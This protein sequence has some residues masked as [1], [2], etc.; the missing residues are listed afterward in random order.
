MCGI[1]GIFD[2]GGKKI[3][4]HSFDRMIDSLSHRGPDG[5]GVYS[6]PEGNLIL[7]HRRLSILDLSESGGQPMPDPSKRYWITFNG[8]IYNFLE[9][10]KELVAL[11]E[12]FTSESDTEIILSAYRQWGADCQLKFNGMWAFAIWDELEKTLFLSRD[13]FGVKPLLYTFDGARLA[14]ASELKAFLFLP[15]FEFEFDPR[16]IATSL[17]DTSLLEP[18]PY[19]LAKEVS[20][21][22]AGHSLSLSKSNGLQIRK[23]WN[24]LDHLPPVPSS[25]RAQIERFR[26]IFTDACRIRMRSD[27]PLGNALSGGLDSSS[28][29][30]VMKGV[31]SNQDRERILESRL[32]AFVALY[33]QTAQDEF[34]FAKEMIERTGVDSRFAP[35]DAALFVKSFDDCLYQHEDLFELPLGPWMLY[36][37]FREENTVISI[38]GHGGDEILG[39]YHHQVESLVYRSL[40]PIPH[41]FR[42]KERLALLNSLYAPGHQYPKASWPL[43]LAKSALYRLRAYPRLQRSFHQVLKTLKQ[44]LKGTK[45]FKWTSAPFDDSIFDSIEKTFPPKL[46]GLNQILFEDFH[47]RTLPMILRNFDRASMAHG[48]EIRAP[49]LDWRL[50]TYAFSLPSETKIGGG[51]TKRI[52][53]EAMRGILPETIRLRKSKI[54]FTNPMFAWI[55]GPLKPFILDTVSSKGFIESPIWNGPSISEYVLESYRVNDLKGVRRAW[56]FIQA[57]RL[58]ERFKEAKTSTG[59]PI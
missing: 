48:V 14:F 54:G 28:V 16:R 19:T 13:R 57:H 7:G 41:P 6:N 4:R 9:L 46:T 50:V 43:L 21:L 29:L 42:L 55:A 31:F 32:K 20:R 52:L 25:S 56:E 53:R 1:A 38:D 45:R 51:F 37:K 59:A 35:I 30:A 23:W 15:D 18:T 44:I 26:E 8:E 24:T 47:I 33:P 49:F 34:P 39:G 40:F 17:E 22:Q 27:V 2:I 5:R 58:M 12:T 36:R 3:D 10:R 11:G